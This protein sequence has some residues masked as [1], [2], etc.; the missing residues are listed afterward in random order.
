M[1]IS[2]HTYCSLFL[3][4]LLVTSI[5]SQAV[6]AEWQGHKKTTE[7]GSHTFYRFCA[8]CHGFNAS[9]DGPFVENLVST[10]P[11]LTR[12]TQNNNGR[13]PWLA[14]YKIIDGTD[15]EPAHGTNEMPI[16]GNQFNL[17][18]WSNDNIH[19]A[20]VIVRGRIFE[21]LVYLQ[22]IQQQ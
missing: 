15:I 14:I 6:D 17:E 7:A 21:L 5:S 18:N 2:L 3:S 9:G 10:P 13:F 12:L 1:Q 22:S 19:F 20:E 4:I 8:V 11:D 16:W